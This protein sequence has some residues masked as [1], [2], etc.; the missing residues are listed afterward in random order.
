LTEK[1]RIN[2][3]SSSITIHKTKTYCIATAFVD[4][5]KDFTHAINTLKLEGWSLAG[6]I[7]VSDSRL[8]QCLQIVE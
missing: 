2:I 3:L 7:S 1:V 5:M 6:G 4:D 8:F